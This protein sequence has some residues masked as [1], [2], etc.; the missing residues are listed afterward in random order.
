MTV[1]YVAE[2]VVAAVAGNS[3]DVRSS[4][5]REARTTDFAVHNPPGE[6]A[7]MRQT[8]QVADSACCMHPHM[9]DKV[10]DDHCLQK[11]TKHKQ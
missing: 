6:E 2:P 5:A 9:A 11:K 7:R 4:D 10:F 3:G 1:A 8:R